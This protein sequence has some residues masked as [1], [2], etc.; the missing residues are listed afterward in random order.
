MLT[1]SKSPE[2]VRADV[3]KFLKKKHKITATYLEDDFETDKKIKYNDE[4]TIH[5]NTS[6]YDKP[7]FDIE[8]K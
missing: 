5:I 2:Q 1:E 8:Y 4:I 3:Y 6:S 7:V